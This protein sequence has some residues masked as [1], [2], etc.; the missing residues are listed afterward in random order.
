MG[1]GKLE[2]LENSRIS[3]L[4]GVI[5]HTRVLVSEDCIERPWSGGVYLLSW[6]KAA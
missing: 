5:K 6:G 1:K 4:T 2:E 3:A